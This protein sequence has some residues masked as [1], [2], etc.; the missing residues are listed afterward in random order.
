MNLNILPDPL[1]SIRNTGGVN[2]VVADHAA[3]FLAA[4]YEVNRGEGL[5]VVHALAQDKDIDVFHCHGLYPIGDGHFDSS[6]SRAN[7]TV[8]QNATHAKLTICI[9]EFSA[10]IL[11]HK[12]HIDPLVTRNGIWLQDYQCGG[13]PSGAVL[14]PKIRLD[15]NAKSTEALWLKQNTDYKILSVA[16]I[17]S[18][19][20]TGKLT[21]Q[22]FIEVLQGC[23]VYLGTTKENNSMATMEAMITGVPV[24]GYDVGFNS[25]WLQNGIGCELVSFGDK[26]ALQEA[27]DKVMSDWQKYSNMARNYAQIFDWQPVIDELLGVYEQINNTHENKSVSIIIPC[28]NYERFL[29]DAIQSALVQ[30]VKSEV[31]VIDDCSSDDSVSIAK[32]YGNKIRL[33]QNKVNLGVAESR[34]KAIQQAQGEFIVCL[35]ADDRL[36][37]DF[38][39]KHLQAFETLQDAIA[40]APIA[41]IDQYGNSQKRLMFTANA[42]VGAQAQGRNQIPSCCMFRRSWFTRAGGY[43]KQCTPAEDAQLWLKIFQLGGLPRKASQTPL[44]EY[45]IHGNNLSNR[46]FPDWWLGSHMNIDEPITDRDPEITIILDEYN[47]GTKET[48]QCLENQK[49]KKWTCQLNQSPN[50]LTKAFPWLNKGTK[51]RASVLSVKS[52]TQLHPNFLQEYVSQIPEWIS[53]PLK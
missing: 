16:K 52:G 30:T 23:A 47:E 34:N 27:L 43:E 20:S 7:N 46:G 36:R 32:Q 49:Y 25:E 21:R 26:L 45:R 12:L 38:V 2:A 28:H 53:H 19:K 31:V 4:G 42:Q 3:G 15:A 6:Y 48:L 1:G 13:S 33:I 22:K 35:D 24:V 51:R 11:R 17:P 10:N 8:L 40:Y 14:F 41:L 44:M 39:E 9:S 50:G 29:D 37:H 5:H 18:I